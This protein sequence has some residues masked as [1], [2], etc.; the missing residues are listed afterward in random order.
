[1]IRTCNPKESIKP[2]RGPS[3]DDTAQCTRGANC[4][5]ERR[6][7]I[8]SPELDGDTISDYS[9]RNEIDRSSTGAQLQPNCGRTSRRLE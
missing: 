2:F 5:A 3:L 6:S 8:R 7:L 1:M 4:V 9:Q